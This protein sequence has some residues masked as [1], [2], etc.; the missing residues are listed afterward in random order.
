MEQTNGTQTNGNA[1]HAAADMK[2]TEETRELR[3]LVDV[4]LSG[5]SRANIEEA[6]STLMHVVVRLEKGAAKAWRNDAD[7]DD[8][9]GLAEEGLGHVNEAICILVEEIHG[10]ALPGDLQRAIERLAAARVDFRQV[11]YHAESHLPPKPAAET[12]VQQ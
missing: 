12:G 9:Q 4:T 7:W 3:R 6:I 2:V 8:V 10:G 11:R 5:R 1:A